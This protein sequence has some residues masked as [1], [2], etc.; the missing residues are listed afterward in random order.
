MIDLVIYNDRTAF[1]PS[2]LHSGAVQVGGFEVA[3]EQIASGIAGTGRDVQVLSPHG[4]GSISAVVERGVYY[5]NARDLE[6]AWDRDVKLE[7][8]AL[9]TARAC[10]IPDW[11]KAD[12][13][14]TTCVDDP[15]GDWSKTFDHLKG[16]TTIVALSEWQ[17]QLYRDLGHER[18]IVIPSMIADDY[19]SYAKCEK[20]PGRYVCLNA[21]NKGTMQTMAAWAKIRRLLK[22]CTLSV[23]SPYSHPEDAAERCAFMGV[24]WL[25]TLSPLAVVDALSTAEAVF[26]VC[27]APETFGVAD[28]IAELVGARVHCWCQNGAGAAPDVLSSPIALDEEGF[29]Q[30]VMRW[31]G[32]MQR[33]APK[34][35]YRV[36]TVIKRWEEVLF[37]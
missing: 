8:R 22:G 17:A 14:F 7:C 3:C 24:R 13:T 25:G 30:D 28:A 23:G 11:I 18:V 35:D 19:A 4:S 33:G 2:V 5:W 37:G 15:R 12:R 20:V 36:S 6:S 26:R 29:R 34:G 31:K 1:A 9:L 21:W 10:P 16:R 32:T 27:V